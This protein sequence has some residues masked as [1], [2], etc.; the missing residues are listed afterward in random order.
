MHEKS[1]KFNDMCNDRCATIGPRGSGSTIYIAV[2]SS[3][4]VSRDNG[5]KLEGPTKKL[6]TH[7][8]TCTCTCMYMCTCTLAARLTL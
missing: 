7:V 8:C 4:L 6:S 5:S 2:S 1:A 3:E